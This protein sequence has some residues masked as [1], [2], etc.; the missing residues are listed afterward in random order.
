MR[1]N[2]R[3]H[4]RD[5]R[6]HFLAVVLGTAVNVVLNVICTWT[7]IP[8]Y[9]DTT[10]TIGASLMDGVFPA[11]VI[12]VATNTICT[13]YESERIYFGCINILIAIL[14]AWY[15]RK[16]SLHKPKEFVVFT[17]VAGL[18]SGFAEAS[19]RWWLIGDSGTAVLQFLVSAAGVAAESIPFHLFLALNILIN[20]LDKG[21]SLGIALLILH[22]I[23]EETQTMIRNGGC[24]QNPL[25]VAQAKESAESGENSIFSLKKRV[26]ILLLAMSVLLV[27][28]TGAVGVRVHFQ[29]SVVERKT[30]IQNA[31]RFA[32]RLVD[33]D[34][35]DEFIAEG[36]SAP[37]Y[38]ETEELLYEVREDAYDVRYLYIVRIDET[39]STYVFDLDDKEEYAGYANA[40]DDL[41]GYEPGYFEPLED[42]VKPYVGDLLSGKEV[43]IETRDAWGWMATAYYPITDAEGNLVCYAGADTTFDALVDYT[44]DF[45]IRTVL[46]LISF[47]VLILAFGLNMADIHITYPTRSMILSIRD[48]I[49]AGS[50]QVRLD[51]SLKK[52]RAID[53]HT[54]DEVERLYHALCDLALDQ[55]EQI[56]SIARFSE[57]NAKMQDGLI[58]TMADLVES[59]DPD[60]GAHVQKTAA[61]VKTIVEGLKRKGYYVE[62][63]TPTFMSDVVRSAP[64]HDIGKIHIPDNVLNK[65]GKLDP[66]E[67]EIMKTHTTAGKRILEKAIQTVG[68][69]N[70]LKEARN[71]AAYHHE[72]WDGNGY[73]EKLHGEEIPLSARI[74]AVA[75][76]FDALT[77]VRV[78]KPAFPMEKAVTIIE[79]GSGTQFDPKCVEVFLEA[80]PEIRKILEQY[81]SVP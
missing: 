77:S 72:R 53:I 15:V 35:I 6:L 9:L 43:L 13:L 61:Y 80:L 54:D 50:D 2:L 3:K 62:K 26:T 34:R 18:V 30:R 37:G 71:M 49:N 57:D 17:L 42:S 16:K 47:F 76:V 56:R 58:I 25:Y 22:L 67:F 39:G 68:A 66:E 32:A 28:I 70:Y 10:G 78:Y 63:I 31:A 41:L 23:P 75:D 46:I 33:P 55:V 14:S 64:L 29:N 20:I 21:L 19:I 51:E 73:P 81:A 4:A 74:M 7:G 79:E 59:R 1:A 8:L 11:I 48:I 5:R 69:E 12:A 24:R 52:I 44:E 27:I 45:S 36:K 65:P 38:S 60:T 40:D